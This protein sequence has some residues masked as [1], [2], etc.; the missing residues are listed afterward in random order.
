MVS[1]WQI[2]ER[3]FVGNIFIVTIHKFKQIF[4][5]AKYIIASHMVSDKI[6]FINIFKRS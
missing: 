1:F 5:G 2:L 6:A 4:F 3:I